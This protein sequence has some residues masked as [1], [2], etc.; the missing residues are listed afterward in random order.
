MKHGEIAVSSLCLS[1]VAGKH[2]VFSTLAKTYEFQ[3]VCLY[4]QGVRRSLSRIGPS[5]RLV[6]RVVHPIH[7]WTDV[8]LRP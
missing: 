7:R 3:S 2:Y 1:A 8:Y 4:L 5:Y 6:V